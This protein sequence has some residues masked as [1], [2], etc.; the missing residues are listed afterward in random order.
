[1]EVVAIVSDCVRLESGDVAMYLRMVLI[2]LFLF[3][4]HYYNYTSGGCLN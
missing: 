4:N 1:M 2:Y 3:K